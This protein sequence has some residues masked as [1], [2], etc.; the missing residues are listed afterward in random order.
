MLTFQ[1]KTQTNVIY[2][3]Q[4]VTCFSLPK[5]HDQ[6]LYNCSHYTGMVHELYDPFMTLHFLEHLIHDG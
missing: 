3:W 4:I 1:I 6:D 2:F 5:M